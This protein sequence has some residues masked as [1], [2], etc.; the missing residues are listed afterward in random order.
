LVFKL[1]HPK[2]QPISAAISKNYRD[3]VTNKNMTAK[4][5]SPAFKVTSPLPSMNIARATA[6]FGQIIQL[7]PDVK[8]DL[9]W[10]TEQTE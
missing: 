6:L 10:P 1:W 3:W 2:K 5:H 9:E 8:S 4:I 7:F